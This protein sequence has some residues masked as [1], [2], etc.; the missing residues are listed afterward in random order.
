MSKNT[1]Y[2]SYRIYIIYVFS[3]LC[4]C[5]HIIVNCESWL[6]PPTPQL[7]FWPQPLPLKETVPQV[8]HQGNLTAYY[9]KTLFVLIFPISRFFDGNAFLKGQSQNLLVQPAKFLHS[10][11][12]IHPWLKG[13]RPLKNHKHKKESE[14]SASLYN[15]SQFFKMLKTQES[16]MFWKRQMIN[17]NFSGNIPLGAEKH[18]FQQVGGLVC[19]RKWLLQLQGG[20][21]QLHMFVAL[22]IISHS[23][24]GG[25]SLHCKKGNPFSRP[26]P[27]CH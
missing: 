16:T 7:G 6:R 4:S 25:G 8:H 23:G 20:R 14:K 15:T 12:E 17:A 11:C 22:T 3:R 19:T 13:A 18:E 2:T 5:A 1:V 10:S 24:E 21:L 26:Q 9:H 27:G